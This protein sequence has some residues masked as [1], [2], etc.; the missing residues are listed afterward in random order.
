MRRQ[1]RDA[2]RPRVRAQISP[3]DAQLLW[4]LARFRIARTKDLVSLAFAGVRPDTAAA[5]LRKLYDAGF[6]DVQAGDRSRESVYGLGAAGRALL[7]TQGV[8]V[9]RRPGQNFGHHLGIVRAWTQIVTCTRTIQ[10]V[11]IELIRPDWE[12]RAA[13][14]EHAVL[15]PDLLVQLR[16]GHGDPGAVVRLAVEVDRGS[17]R[18]GALRDKLEA[19]QLALSGSDGLFG[20][21]DVG[22]AFALSGAGVARRRAIE[23]LTVQH[24][25]GWWVLWTEDDGPAAA[26]VAIAEALQGDRNT[27]PDDSPYRKGSEARGSHG[28]STRDRR[29]GRGLSQ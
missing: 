4:L 29:E 24:W 17:E 23:A 13:V 7:E 18:N 8:E 22:L 5:R 11:S 12:I 28:V 16:V 9:G 14:G 3:R 19:Y 26:L 21:R 10:G 6:V 2:R 20:W 1:A 15:V 25:T 27:S